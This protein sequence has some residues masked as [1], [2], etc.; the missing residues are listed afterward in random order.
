MRFFQSSI[1]VEYFQLN[2]KSNEYKI[3][4]INEGKVEKF[5]S[6]G[7]FTNEAQRNTEEISVKFSV[8]VAIASESG[9]GL[10]IN[11]VGVDRVIPVAFKL[12]VVLFYFTENFF[13]GLLTLKREE[14]G[15]VDTLITLRKPC[16]DVGLMLL[17]S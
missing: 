11:L 9:K 3:D 17:R 16:S 1:V 4:F 8:F 15:G 6:G 14:Q 5:N 10:N 12:F 7:Y 13:H 2:Y